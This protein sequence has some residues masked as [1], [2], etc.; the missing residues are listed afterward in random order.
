VLL[1]TGECVEMAG[2]IGVEAKAA[3][4]EPMA[5]AEDGDLTVG[6][7]TSGEAGEGFDGFVCG[8]LEAALAAVEEEA[9][10]DG[11][12]GLGH[13]VLHGAASKAAMAAKSSSPG[14]SPPGCKSSQLPRQ[15]PRFV[16]FAFGCDDVCGQS[17]NVVQVLFFLIVGT[18]HG[19]TPG[20]GSRTWRHAMRISSSWS[21]VRCASATMGL[22]RS[23][24]V[25]QTV[26]KADAASTS[27]WSAERSAAFSA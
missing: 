16:A 17:P 14:G 15:R 19:F 1:F 24:S 4:R 12:G 18:D 2:D 13:G 7:E 10:V 25:S 22:S 8:E 26:K 3:D 5:D 9:D 20:W 11:F 23:N 6:G 21:A 27:C